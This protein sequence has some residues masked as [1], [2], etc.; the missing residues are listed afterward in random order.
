MPVELHCHNTTGLAPLNYLIGIE[1]GIQAH[2][3][4]QPAGGQRAVAAVDGDDAGATSSRPATR[5]A[6]DTATLPPVAEHFERVALQE[7]HPLGAVAEYDRRIYDHQL[8]GGM[9]GTFKAQLV[10]HGMEDRFDAVLEEIPRVREELGYPVSATPFS[11][12]IGTQ[13]LLNVV[14]GDRYSITTDEVV[15]YT[16]E[17]YGKPPAPID[18]DVKDRLLSSPAGRRL[19]G[20]RRPDLTLEELRVQSGGPH[21][22]DEDLFRLIFTPQEDLD[23]TAAAGPLR[24]GYVFRETPADLLARAMDAKQAR[25]VSL[26]SPGVSIDLAR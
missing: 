18:P 1:H 9:T 11:Q 21:V 13:A 4:L 22:S 5:T 14:T 10:E 15:L 16:M 20:F 24:T 12:L 8:P 23:A 6:I 3:H 19:A 2:P 26:R 25:R 17:A 7:G